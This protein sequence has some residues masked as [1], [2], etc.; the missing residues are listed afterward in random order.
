MV[1]LDTDPPFM[2][3]GSPHLLRNNV[4]NHAE[5]RGMMSLALKVPS[6][7][8]GPTCNLHGSLVWPDII[9]S[10]LSVGTA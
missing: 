8:C 2:A 3:L 1:I 4:H 9:S 10:L 5:G 7:I 6:K